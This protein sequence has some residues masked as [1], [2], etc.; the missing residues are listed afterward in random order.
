MNRRT[1][2]TRRGGPEV[3]ELIEEGVPEP[4]VGEVRIRVRYAGVAFGDLLWMSGVVPGSPRPPYTPGYDVTGTV[5]AVGEGVTELRP[6]QRVVAFVNYGGYAELVCT[7]SARV[8]PVPEGLDLERVACLPLNYATAYRILVDECGL[9]A[10]R[11]ALIHGASGGVGTAFLEVGRVLGLDLYGTASAA[12]H[13]LVERLGATP[14]DYRSEDFV[15]RIAELTGDGVDAVVDHIGGAHLRRS[16]RTLRRGGTLIAT[17]SYGALQEGQGGL[18]TVLGL[19]RMPLWSALPNGRKARLVAIESLP[20]RD[21]GRY[22]AIV[23]ELLS[24]LQRGDLDPVIADLYPL[25]RAP[26][27]LTR[28]RSGGAGGKLLLDCTRP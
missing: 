1:V 25:A 28:L 14:I 19:L 27:A 20:K 3:L 5:D 22:R 16:F 4:G 24:W 8:V 7:E 6:G 10:G 2:V 9:T 21:P 13:P 18:E 11:R 26:E 12:R 15:T 23:H 17:S